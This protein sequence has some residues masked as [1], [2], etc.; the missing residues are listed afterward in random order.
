MRHRPLSK[1]LFVA[2]VL[3]PLLA[4]TFAIGVIASTAKAQWTV[5]NL[6]PT[7]ATDSFAYGASGARQ[8]GYAVIN[9][10]NHASLWSASAAS[11][12]D[13]NPVWAVYSIAYGID[14][15]HQVGNAGQSGGEVASLWNGT[16]GSWVNLAP[17]GSWAKINV[18]IG[19][20][21]GRQVGVADVDGDLRG[22][23][24]SGTAVSWIDLTPV[25]TSE[26]IVYGISF[27]EQVGSTFG[28]AGLWRGSAA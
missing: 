5:T 21:A 24:W 15:D 26:A 17:E 6:H 12:V 14:G 1:G 28:H 23:L 10:H 8:A 19:V 9:G 16:A 27:G 3:R 11:W 20:S 13:L 2:R 7:G 25:G 18:A 4:C 22:A